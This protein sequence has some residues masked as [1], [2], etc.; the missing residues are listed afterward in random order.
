[1]SNAIHQVYRHAGDFLLEHKKD[2]LDLDIT[3]EENFDPTRV[4]YELAKFA[5]KYRSAHHKMANTYN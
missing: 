4:S 3:P 1:M 5:N 2:F